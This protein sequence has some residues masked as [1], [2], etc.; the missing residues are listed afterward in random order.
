MRLLIYMILL[1]NL[2]KNAITIY[3]CQILYLHYTITLNKHLYDIGLTI[4]AKCF[5]KSFFSFCLKL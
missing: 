4:I 3:I 1:K 5:I 2:D